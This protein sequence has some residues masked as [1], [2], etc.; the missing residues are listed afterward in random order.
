MRNYLALVAGLIVLAMSG[1]ALAQ[2]DPGL[3]ELQ[4][5]DRRV[6]TISYQLATRNTELCRE[7]ANWSGLTFHDLNQYGPPFRQRVRESFGLSED[8]RPAILAMV[9]GSP[10]DLAG[11]RE[12]ETILA[13]NGVPLS[14]QPLEQ[15]A[16]YRSIGVF[17]SLMEAA[18]AAGSVAVT[19]RDGAGVLRTVTLKGVPGCASRVEVGPGRSLNAGADGEIV[20][21]SAAMVDFVKSDD[22]LALLTAHEMAHNI[23]HHRER[24]DAQKVSRGFMSNF[25]RSAARIKVTEIEADYVGLYLAA[26]AGYDISAGVGFWKRMGN[27]VGLGLFHGATHPGWGPRQ[28]MVRATIAEI[29]AKKA[30]GQPVVP[31]PARIAY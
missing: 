27:K 9:K 29:A 3:V 28:D 12:N 10:A 7:H 6:A 4:N 23:L 20:Q 16:S 1:V 21:V 5:I 18:L 8:N 22:E 15:K 11:L 17:N 30:A 31:D 19:S 26:R 2:P 13:I 14:L 25:G 24:L